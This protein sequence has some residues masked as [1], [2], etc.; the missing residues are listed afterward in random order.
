MEWRDE[1][2]ILAVRPHGETSAIAEILTAGHGRCL[3]LVRGGRGRRL[4]PMLQPGNHVG[5]VWHARL[6]EHLGHF[7]LEPLHLQAGLIIDEPLR[8]LGVTSMTALAQLLP[9]REPHPKLFSALQVVLSA[10]DEDRI[11]PALLV[12]WEMGL[13]DEL[14][15]GLDLSTCAATGVNTDLV[16]VSPKTGRAVSREAG[17]PYH[18]RLFQLPGFLRGE[19]SG[20][21]GDVMD[22]LRLTGYF[23]ER[24]VFGPRAVDM[25]QARQMLQEK[26]GQRTH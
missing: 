10:I 20:D 9:E 18:Q 5:C 3:G 14:G 23:L 17:L 24:H 8:L 19:G 22:G 15:F 25:P 2:I 13:L 26:L 16:Y 1:G 12:R 7:V 4:R 11:W 21:D 6:E